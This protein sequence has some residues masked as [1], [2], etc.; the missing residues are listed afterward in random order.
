MDYLGIDIISK[1]ELEV[2]WKIIHNVDIEYI[3]PEATQKYIKLCYINIT[4]MI[5]I[6]EAILLNRYMIVG[7]LMYDN[8]EFELSIDLG[9]IIAITGNLTCLL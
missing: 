5:N 7:Q 3:I 6:H 1:D 9:C 2:W 4:S 8:F